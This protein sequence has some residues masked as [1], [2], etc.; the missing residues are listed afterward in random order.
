MSKIIGILGGMGPAATIDLFRKIVLNTKAETDQEHLPIFIYNN[1]K[2]PAVRESE[3][4]LNQ[5][6]ISARI[7]EKAGVDFIIMP[8]NTAHIWQD[9]IK[10]ALTIPFYSMVDL[11]IETLLRDYKHK[12]VLL[13]ATATTVDYGLYQKACQNTPLEIITPNA[14]EQKIINKTIKCVKAGKLEDNPYLKDLNR[15][16]EKYYNESISSL[17]GGCT[18]IPLLFD[19]LKNDMTKIDPTLLLAKMSVKKAL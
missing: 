1:T 4:A 13:L 10:E 16:L 12:K 7:L 9:E 6:V 19:Y 5:L 11:T 18:E 14:E 3:K 17:I 15:V 2:I 8:C